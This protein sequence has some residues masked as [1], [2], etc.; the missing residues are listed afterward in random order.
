MTEPV[1]LAVPSELVDIVVERAAELVL[2]RV[3][4]LNGSEPPEP[5]SPYLSVEEAAAFLRCNRQRVY[6]LLSS[7]RL[8][9]FKEGVNTAGPKARSS[10]TLVLRAEVE[11]LVERAS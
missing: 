4:S 1:T 10:R 7:G 3:G 8:T 2:E 11:A 9:R 5:P 6:D